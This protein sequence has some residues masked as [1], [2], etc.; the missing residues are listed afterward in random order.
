MIWLATVISTLRWCGRYAEVARNICRHTGH[1][2]RSG[3]ESANRRCADLSLPDYERMRAFRQNIE[4][5]RRG[6]DY[7]LRESIYEIEADLHD[8]Q[9][10][11]HSKV[12]RFPKGH[13]VKT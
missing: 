9:L 5:E 1:L 6:T 7:D 11:L 8:L 3:N 2:F 12:P 4:S 10:Y 13:G